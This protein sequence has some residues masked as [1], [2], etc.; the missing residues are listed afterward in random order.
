MP[1]TPTT[2]TPEGV[3]TAR[4]AQDSTGASAERSTS[5]PIPLALTLIQAVML[6]GA[7]AVMMVLTTVTTSW[8]PWLVYA[9]LM[10]GGLFLGGLVRRRH[11]GG[12]VTRS[13]RVVAVSA[14]AAVPLVV[15]VLLAESLGFTAWGI[16]AM[17]VV[18][19]GFT[20]LLRFDDVASLQRAREGHFVQ[21]TATGP[22][23]VDGPAPASPR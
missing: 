17:L 4:T 19:L 2:P 16:L 1:A 8:W 5:R 7:L 9:V 10:Y 6:C 12:R 23:D 13:G 15:L 21:P 14:I 22:Q 20:A 18:F 3:R 11:L